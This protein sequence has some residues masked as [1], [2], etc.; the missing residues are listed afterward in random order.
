MTSP[1]HPPSS[2]LFWKLVPRWDI[3]VLI[4]YFA[5]GVSFYSSEEGMS[6]I[7]SLYFCMITFTT[8]GFGD[9][10][11]STVICKLFTCLF[12]FVGL[13]IIATLVSNLLDYIIEEREKKKA[14]EKLKNT[15]DEQ[16]SALKETTSTS[17]ECLGTVIPTFALPILRGLQQSIVIISVNLLIGTI[18]YSHIVDNYSY[19]DAFYLSTMII[20][21]VGYGDIK[22]TNDH[23]R[24]FTVLYS[25]LGTIVTGN[26]LSKFASALSDYKQAQLE[27]VVLARPLNVV[28]LLEMD[29]DKTN[30]GVSKEEFVLYKLK[31]MGALDPDVIHRAEAQ[32]HLLDITKTGYLSVED[33]V[34]FEGR[35]QDQ[36]MM[37]QRGSAV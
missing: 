36:R 10:T 21:T 2:P 3:V 27:A 8:V 6:F 16:E 11:P 35:V 29:S 20:T 37:L 4:F 34:T 9:Y 15:F 18:F 31:A 24:A 28:S 23:A 32:F 33:I 17:S 7:L 22:P 1:E 14:E 5:A 25:L 12:V 26:A 19:I 13:A 30:I